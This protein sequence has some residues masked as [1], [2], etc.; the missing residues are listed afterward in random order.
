[1]DNFWVSSTGAAITGLAKDSFLKDFTV[2]PD[3]TS[4]EA[5]VKSFLLTEKQDKH[6]KV[7]D[8]Y[9]EITWKIVNGDFKNQEVSQKLKVF[10]GK[11]ESIDRN[12]NM[13]MLVMKLFEFKPTHMGTPTNMELSTMNNKMA[14]IVIGEWEMPK[15]DGT[16]MMY[17]NNVREVHPVGTIPTETGVKRETAVVT[18]APTREPLD[19][20]LSR[21]R[22]HA[23]NA[24]SDG[25]D[26]PF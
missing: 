17:G 12:K 2:I 24:T 19:S 3:K 20:A 7:L 4:C 5:F 1:M 16:G 25:S 14:S 13:L 22:A 21:Q 11:P 15:D 8:T 10:S 18:A 9:F 6:G 23:Q 26:I